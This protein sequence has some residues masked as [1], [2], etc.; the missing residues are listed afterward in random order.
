VTQV[1]PDEISP[2]DSALVATI[3]GAFVGA[4]LVVPFYG[5]LPLAAV[6]GGILAA[7]WIFRDND[8]HP[9]AEEG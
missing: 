9:F 2:I 5:F 1:K 7:A 8:P 4:I 6:C 3:G